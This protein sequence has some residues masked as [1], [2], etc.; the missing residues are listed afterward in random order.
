MDSGLGLRFRRRFKSAEL[1]VPSPGFTRS[2]YPP[3]AHWG[4]HFWQLV[5]LGFMDDSLEG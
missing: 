5:P 1:A 2:E 3:T 4:S